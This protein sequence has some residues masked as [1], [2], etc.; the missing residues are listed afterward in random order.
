MRAKMKQI[1]SSARRL[2]K[3]LGVDEPADAADGPGD[4]YVYEVL[5]YAP[6]TDRDLVQIATERVGRLIEL[7]EGIEAASVLHRAATEG[8]ESGDRIGRPHS[9]QRAR[10]RRD[11]EPVDCLHDE[12]LQGDHRLGADGI[13]GCSGPTE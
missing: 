12:H 11:R 3:H 4:P 10:R 7:M 13:D 1:S 2:M 6:E 8:V 9:A 5:T